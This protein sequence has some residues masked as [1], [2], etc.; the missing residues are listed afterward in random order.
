MQSRDSSDANRQAYAGHTA[1]PVSA[2]LPDRLHC[3]VAE[4]ALDVKTRQ[5]HAK[6]MMIPDSARQVDRNG[7]IEHNHVQVQKGPHAA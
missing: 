5:C 1:W 4:S 2:W 6:I 7:A 3:K